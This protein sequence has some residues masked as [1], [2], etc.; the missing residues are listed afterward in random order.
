MSTVCA[1]RVGDFRTMRIVPRSHTCPSCLTELGRIRA[2]PD[3]HYGL[4][5]VVCPSCSLATVRQRHPDIEFWRSFRRVH[6][7]MR[8]LTVRLGLTIG[9]AALI[10]LF[11]LL[12]N[13]MFNAEGQ[14]S[15]EYPFTSS[16][17]EM[18]MSALLI[19]GSST[20]LMMAVV[21]LYRHRSIFFGI[22]LMLG[23]TLFI[24]TIDYTFIWIE[25]AIADLFA[26]TSSERYPSNSE[27]TGRFMRFAMIGSCSLLGV[28]PAVLLGGIVNRSERRRFRRLL[29]KRRKQ[30]RTHD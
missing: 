26:F 23:L 3:P 7:A 14:F 18:T 2:V 15:P 22:I 10:A 29:K 28:I 19:L 5:V 21:M 8:N 4:P 20:L 11:V 24:L 1:T 25:H 27:M 16:D 12:S 17:P 30:R 9:G 13:R 6:S